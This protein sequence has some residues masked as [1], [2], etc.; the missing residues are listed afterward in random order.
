VTGRGLRDKLT[1]LA[2]LA[3]SSGL[4]GSIGTVFAVLAWLLLLGRLAVYS[5]VLNVVRWEEV[6]GTVT[7]EIELPRHPDRVAVEA[8]RAGEAR[9]VPSQG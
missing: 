8:T 9:P 4:Y 5:V 1:G 3:G 7:A 2:W 6:H